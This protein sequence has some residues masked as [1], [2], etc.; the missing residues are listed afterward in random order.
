MLLFLQRAKESLKNLFVGIASV[1]VAVAVVVLSVLAL[2]AVNPYLAALMP[3]WTPTAVVSGGVAVIALMLLH[4]LGEK[5]RD[6]WE[7]IRSQRPLSR[8]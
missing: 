7:T 1:V 4:K 3:A 8:R 2:Q 6:D 5:I